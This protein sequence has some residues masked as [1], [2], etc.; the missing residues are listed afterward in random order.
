MKRLLS[1]LSGR[2]RSSHASAEQDRTIAYRLQQRF[3]RRIEQLRIEGFQ[4]YVQNRV[5]S[6]Y[7]TV[8]QRLDRDLLLALVREVPGVIATESHI[9]II[10]L[11]TP[12]RQT[13]PVKPYAAT[14]A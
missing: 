2:S 6:I 11:A 12:T 9:Q 7:G 4:F 1:L 13:A 14:P 10:R 3:E 8:H 5:V